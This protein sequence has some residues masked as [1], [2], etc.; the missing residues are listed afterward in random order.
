MSL[1][2]S[3]DLLLRNVDAYWITD[4]SRL[5]LQSTR[6]HL[7]ILERL[8]RYPHRNAILGREST[9]EE[10]GFLKQPGAGF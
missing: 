3:L 2:F 5:T 9:P 6:H 8:R 4:Q 10:I 7:A 1:G